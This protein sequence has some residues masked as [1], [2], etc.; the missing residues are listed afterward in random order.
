MLHYERP[1]WG[2]RLPRTR[3]SF[4]S[5]NWSFSVG[6]WSSWEL[7]QVT[8]ETFFFLNLMKQHLKLNS[9][10]FLFQ[11]ISGSEIPLINILTLQ[12]YKKS[13]GTHFFLSFGNLDQFLIRSGLKISPSCFWILEVASANRLF[14]GNPDIC[15]IGTQCIFRE[16]MDFK[17]W[18]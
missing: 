4:Y 14:L 13:R 16:E 3:S 5:F 8:R 11:I 2:E 1:L 15:V 17:M 18:K 7:L 10:S 9:C 6:P 12:G